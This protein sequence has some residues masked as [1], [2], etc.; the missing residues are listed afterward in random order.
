ML[1]RMKQRTSNNNG[2]YPDF[3][4]KEYEIADI[5]IQLPKL[6]KNSELNYLIQLS[7]GAK[8]RRSASG[9]P[10]SST[11][12][13][14]SPPTHLNNRSLP[15]PPPCSKVDFISSPN[16]PLSFIVHSD[17]DS[18]PNKSLK[19]KLPKK[20]TKEEWQE[21]EMDVKDRNCTLKKEV[22]IVMEHYKTLKAQNLKLKSM[23]GKTSNDGLQELDLFVEEPTT[24][25]VPQQQQQV[26]GVGAE[27]RYVCQQPQ[28]TFQFLDTKP[29]FGSESSRF[30]QPQATM[31]QHLGPLGIPDLNFVVNHDEIEII[32]DDNRYNK[33]RMGSMYHPVDDLRK[34][35]TSEA[36]KK[37]YEV[38]KAKKS[39]KPRLQIRL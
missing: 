15:P 23:L 38:G 34:R 2:G 36:R 21:L 33:H 26:L 28:T 19:R 20:K 13:P 8:R 14:S 30:L 22:Q 5:L 37:R 17:S 32:G 11:V 6:I 4:E 18:K 29:Q 1:V 27:P 9:T 12:S 39:A 10:S 35:E 31:S 24:A 7:W 25:P 3:S 16:T